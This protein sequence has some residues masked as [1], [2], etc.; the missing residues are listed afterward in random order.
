MLHIKQVEGFLLAEA[1]IGLVLISTAIILFCENERYLAQNRNKAVEQYKATEELVN[2]SKKILITS[3]EQVFSKNET[4]P[5]QDKISVKS[6]Y[7]TFEV[8]VK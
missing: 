5:F 4:R 2:M 6:R 1:T 8:K 7:G 3:E